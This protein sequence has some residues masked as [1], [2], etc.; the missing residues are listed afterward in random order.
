MDNDLL[1]TQIFSNIKMVLS[2][3]ETK[4]YIKV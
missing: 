1:Y 4:D 2:N 3:T